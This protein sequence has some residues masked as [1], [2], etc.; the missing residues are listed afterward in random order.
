MNNIF[1]NEDCMKASNCQEWKHES[2]AL[3]NDSI[4]NRLQACNGFVT[5]ISTNIEKQWHMGNFQ[6]T[7]DTTAMDAKREL[8]YM[9]YHNKQYGYAFHLI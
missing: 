4:Q 6:H 7:I 8:H 1:I 2:L 3:V 5:Q 9:P